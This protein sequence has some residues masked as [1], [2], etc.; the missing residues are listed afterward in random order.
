MKTTLM[1]IFA[2]TMTVFAF[3]ADPAIA[4]DLEVDLADV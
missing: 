2:I 4:D 1:T 3:D